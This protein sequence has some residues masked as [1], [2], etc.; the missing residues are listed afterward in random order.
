M[1]T[2][3][4]IPVAVGLHLQLPLS[5]LGENRILKSQPLRHQESVAELL[6]AVLGDLYASLP[7][8][9]GQWGQVR[10]GVALAH[11][12]CQGTCPLPLLLLGRGHRLCPQRTHGGTGFLG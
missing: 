8:R 12:L 1:Q 3:R 9:G 2:D 10:C 6:L 4:R 5:E 7:F 11:C